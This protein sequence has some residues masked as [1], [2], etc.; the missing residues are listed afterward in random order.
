MF[1][2]YLKACAFAVGLT[3]GGAVN[4]TDYLI[5]YSMDALEND[6]WRAVAS[7]FEADVK[8]LA[9]SMGKDIEVQ[10]VVADGDVGRQNAQIRDLL[11]SNRRF[12]LLHPRIPRLSSPRSPQRRG[13]VSRWSPISAT[14]T[15]MQKV[16]PRFLPWN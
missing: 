5:G 14:V 10:L 8:A 13:R 7:M 9:E 1:A 11:A 4:A 3:F 16:R 6:M 2:K 12:C 15:P